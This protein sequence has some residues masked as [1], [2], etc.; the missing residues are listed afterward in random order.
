ME[1][2]ENTHGK[3]FIMSLASRA[4]HISS[5]ILDKLNLPREHV[6]VSCTRS[7]RQCSCGCCFGRGIP[8]DRG[9][10]REDEFE[11]AAEEEGLFISVLTLE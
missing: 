8:E 6:I 1:K 7:K 10:V 9:G 4:S 3:P 2:L 5:S 11:R